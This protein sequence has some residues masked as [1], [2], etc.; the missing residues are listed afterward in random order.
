MTRQEW[1]SSL[2]RGFWETLMEVEAGRRI[3]VEHESRWLNLTGFCLRPGYGLAVDDWRVAQLWRLYPAGVYFPK[4]ELCRAEWWILWRRVAGGLTAGQQATLADPLVADW[5]TYLRKAGSGVKGRSPTFQFGPHESAE[6]WRV[7]GSL[8]LLKPATKVEIGQTLFDRLARE[9]APA[10]RDAILFALGRTGAR[11][12]VYGPLNT[13]VDAAV[14]EEWVR[15]LIDP[16]PADEKAAFTAVLLT[17]R[18]GDR[19]RDVSEPVRRAVLQWLAARRAAPHL[20]ELVEAG[21]HLGEEEQRT[22]FGES[23]PRGLRIE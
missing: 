10:V 1:P 16:N 3:G 8:E 18:T 22:V 23:L 7:L 15:R 12:P 17:R 6:V 4:N 13:L 9:K 20:L 2:M 21:G 11:V 19:Y 14:A 5:R